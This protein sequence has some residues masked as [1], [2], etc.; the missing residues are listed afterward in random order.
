MNI[1]SPFVDGAVAEREPTRLGMVAPSSN[2]VLE[3]LCQAM[4]AG[5]PD[6]SLHF[7]RSPVT[8]ISLSAA[9]L[10]QF[11]HD[12]MASAATLL[13]H[14]RP[15]SI[16]W[17]A[18]S[19]AWLGLDHDRAL[20]AR[21]ARETGIPATSAILA[22]AEALR[23][24]RFRRLALVTPYQAA[25]QASIVRTLTDERF[26]IVAERHLGLVENFGFAGVASSTLARLTRDVAASRPQAILILCTNLRG[27]PIVDGLERELKIPIIDS[28]AAGVW[29]AVSLAG[30]APERIKG[31]GSLFRN[32]AGLEIAAAG[33]GDG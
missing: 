16:C 33:L 5:L 28:V 32:F 31:W 20:C 19:A 15:A 3:P 18:T 14:A 11:D 23:R 4:L 6:V 17:N 26:E 10:G 12:A 2:T 13:A 25:V 24:G 7:S 8:E 21:I 1:S 27:A 9:A 29:G 22:M 30:I